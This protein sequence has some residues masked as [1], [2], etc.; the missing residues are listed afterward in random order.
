MLGAI[1][2]DIVGS[3]WEFKEEKPD[4]R[5]SPL[6]RPESIMSDDSIL[7]IAT[8]EAILR[9]QFYTELYQSFCR[10]YVNYGYGPSFMNW[11][12]A[13][14]SYTKPNHSWGNGSAMRVSPIGWAFN[15][16]QSVMIEAQQSASITHCHPEGIKGAQSTALAVFMARAGASK[17]DIAQVMVEWFNYN[18]D[19]DLEDY[20][21]EY[22]FDVSCMGTVPPAI[23]CVL[24]A[25]SFEEVL[26][27]GLYIG[28][29][30]DTLLSIAGAV[31]EP[32]YGIP[33]DIRE[34]T[35]AIVLKNSPVLLATI[36]EF[37]AKYGCGKAMPSTEGFDVLGSLR[38]L[39]GKKR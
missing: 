34:K 8:A 31:A 26:Q 1:C 21:I 9:G 13:N 17:E 19:I 23:A 29:D 15:T 6:F 33:K 18:L 12:H 37:E 5:K 14:E 35:E 3:Y 27:N 39:L 25:S 22:K 28:G 24:Q 2:G 7:T 20:H 4:D 36:H 32:L 38:K 16:P 30:T 10:R 11:A